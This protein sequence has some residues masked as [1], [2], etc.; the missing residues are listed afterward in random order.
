MRERMGTEDFRTK[1]AQLVKQKTGEEV[2][3]TPVLTEERVVREDG[4]PSWFSWRLW[5][6]WEIVVLTLACVA[7]LL[8]C[9]GAA[10]YLWRI[11]HKK[12]RDGA[13]FSRGPHM[14]K[15]AQSRVPVAQ[16]RMFRPPD[17]RI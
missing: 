4:G 6:P 1:F 2:V 3:A 14:P 9:I 5:R 11:N 13:V 15:E 10:V 16:P 12:P 7:T 8:C 17:M